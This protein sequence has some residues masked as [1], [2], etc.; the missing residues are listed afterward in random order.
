M[1]YISQERRSE[2]EAECRKDKR[3]D[4]GQAVV[5]K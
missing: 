2:H 1:K 3:T 5:S 4:G